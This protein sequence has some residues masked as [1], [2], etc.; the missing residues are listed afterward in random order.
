MN[1]ELRWDLGH[2]T[3]SSSCGLLLLSQK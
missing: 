3:F 2:L 1:S